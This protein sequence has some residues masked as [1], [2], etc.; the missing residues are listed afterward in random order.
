MNKT[1]LSL[2]ALLLAGTAVGAR[3][4]IQIGV[5]TAVTGSMASFGAQMQAGVKA[6]AD[7]LNAHGGI[8]GEKI[9]LVV[10]DDACDPKQGVSA[11]NQLVNK[12]VSFVIGH[13]CTGPSVPASDVYAE[14]GIIMISPTATAPVLTERGLD[15][16]F[17]VVGR[18]DQQ[19]QVAADYIAKNIG[20]P[21]V[22]IL[23]D[24]QAYGKGL[25]DSAQAA[26]AAHGIQ[27][28]MTG[29]IN[30]G[31]SDFS[32]LVTKMKGEG[33]NAV[34][35]GGYHNEAGQIVRQMKQ[36]NLDATLIAGDGL[37][38]P[39]FWAITGESGTGTLFTFAPDPSANPQA[40]DLVRN[41]RA[42]NIEPA[43]F[44]L[45]SYAAMQV[46]AQAVAQAGEPEPPAVSDA[47]RQGRFETVIGTLDF[48]EKGDLTNPSYVIYKW[49]KGGY[50]PASAA[51]Q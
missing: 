31:E 5:V 23:H 44:T 12:G 2:A 33:V 20:S 40:A 18:D 25:A 36:A 27:P 41:L 21:K 51:A 22:A 48:N 35:Y 7:D 37:A 4:E 34:Y 1:S 26:L 17:R 38:N 13:M 30:P 45:N 32:A 9:E 11:A 42:R 49:A 43:L 3:A 16:V 10:E 14:E 28:A 50:V 46:L 39:D 15:N 6:A 47:L 24:K 29:S 8:A 19:G